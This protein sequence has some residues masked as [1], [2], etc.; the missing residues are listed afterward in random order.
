MLNKASYLVLLGASSDAILFL[1]MLASAFQGRV[2][3]WAQ[4]CPWEATVFV[5]SRVCD[6]S[7]HFVHLLHQNV[8]HRS[9]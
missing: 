3:A 9:F 4:L 6:C 7:L 5:D 1:L 8:A 2:M